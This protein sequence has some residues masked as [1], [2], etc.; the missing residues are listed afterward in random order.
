MA[1]VFDWQWKKA[2]GVPKNR[3]FI[4]SACGYVRYANQPAKMHGKYAKSVFPGM[5][6]W[7]PLGND[8]F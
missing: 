5:S 7:Q 4:V 3:F 2:S 6:F 1:A 8:L